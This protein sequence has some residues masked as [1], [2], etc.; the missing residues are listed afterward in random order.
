MI[1][2]DWHV[3]YMLSLVEQHPYYLK[4][5]TNQRSVGFFRLCAW[6]IEE[7][8]NISIQIDGNVIMVLNA[9]ETRS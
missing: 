4:L 6:L 9:L 3:G 8:I 7:F 5:T 2:R 1:R